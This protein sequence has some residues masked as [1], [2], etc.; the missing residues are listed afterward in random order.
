M[1]D[2]EIEIDETF[3]GGKARNMHSA[4]RREK[5]QG[6]GPNGKAV[7]MGMLQRGGKVRTAV[8]ENRDKETLNGHVNK[9]VAV[10]SNV[11]TDELIS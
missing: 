4:K 10:G 8:I 3:I 2:G 5:I 1:L 7:V 6:R 9:N 11:F